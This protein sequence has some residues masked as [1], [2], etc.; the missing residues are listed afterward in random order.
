MSEFNTKDSESE[1]LPIGDKVLIPVEI[2]DSGMVW[3]QEFPLNKE[4]SDDEKREEAKKLFDEYGVKAPSES[5][6]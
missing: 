3:Y 2:D 1:S 4:L 6:E 5:Q